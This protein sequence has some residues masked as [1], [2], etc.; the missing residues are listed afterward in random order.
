VRS[1]I[2]QSLSLHQQYV[3]IGSFDRPNLFY[4]VKLIPAPGRLA[5]FIDDIITDI[6][7]RVAH[8]ESTIIYCATVHDTEQV[9]FWAVLIFLFLQG[10]LFNF[11]YTW[12]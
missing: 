1:D 6:K 11:G 2:Q 5:S 7:S 10:K 12:S 3:Y 4:G 9:I 8:R